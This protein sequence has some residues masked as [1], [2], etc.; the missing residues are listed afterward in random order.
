MQ[1]TPKR[2]GINDLSFINAPDLSSLICAEALV[3]SGAV[4]K[5]DSFSFALE[6]QYHFS[7]PCAVKE[8]WQFLAP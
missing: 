8:T 2:V 1:P 3:K 5:S 6:K 4:K 7:C